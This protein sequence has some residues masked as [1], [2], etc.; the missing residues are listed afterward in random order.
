MHA[1]CR[2]P[3]TRPKGEGM[4][5][6]GGQERGVAGKLTCL[7]AEGGRSEVEGREEEEPLYYK[8]TA[9]KLRK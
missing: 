9:E 3:Q 1:R 2:S 4:E 5:G 7:A 8:T 6:D